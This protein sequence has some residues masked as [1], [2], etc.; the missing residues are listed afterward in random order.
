TKYDI[1][2]GVTA[3]GWG[4]HALAG[5]ELLSNKSTLVTLGTSNT[6]YPT[7]NAVKTYVDNAIGSISIPTNYWTTN[8]TQTGLTGNKTTDGALI[9]NGTQATPLFIQ[10]A[11]S[12]SNSSIAFG[13]NSTNNVFIG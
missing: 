2:L 8:T 9:F 3:N 5:Y 4:N 12:T 11:G 10:R 13:F 1:A 7:Q 6:L